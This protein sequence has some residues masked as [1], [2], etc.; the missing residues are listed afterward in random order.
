MTCSAF[1]QMGGSAE[2]EGGGGV[3]VG[4]EGGGVVGGSLTNSV[5]LICYRPPHPLLPLICTVLQCTYFCASPNTC[6]TKHSRQ[7]CT[8]MPLKQRL[9]FGYFTSLHNTTTPCGPLAVVATEC[10]IKPLRRSIQST[11]L[12]NHLTG[13][14]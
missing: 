8:L 11:K 14:N 12:C 7:N 1:Q 4:G 5:F 3:V 9:L 2:E 10:K 6:Y 13:M